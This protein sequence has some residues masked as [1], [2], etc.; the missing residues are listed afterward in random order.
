MNT[1]LESDWVANLLGAVALAVVDR[2][3][4]RTAGDRLDPS[5]VAALLHVR[6][7]PGATQEPLMGALALSQPGTA[8]LV[9]RL[10]D[11]GLLSRRTGNDAR[12]RFLTL[13][14]EGA[15]VADDILERRLS[16]VAPLIEALPE[17]DRQ[18]LARLLP[19]L[20]DALV[21]G[22]EDIARICRLCDLPRCEA[23][24]ACPTAMAAPREEPS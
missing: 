4:D 13:T 15:S 6:H 16:V 2:V 11:A 9:S 19:L 22:V 24:G 1:H 20:L 18:A 8:H 17:S 10:E 21:V 5:A 14:P 12:K 7:H 3:N 23:A